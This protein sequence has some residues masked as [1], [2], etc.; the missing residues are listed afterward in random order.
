MKE[1]FRNGLTA[2]PPFLACF[3]VINTRYRYVSTGIVL[4]VLLKLI[5]KKFEDSIYCGVWRD[6]SMIS[7]VSPR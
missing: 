5:Y 1:M 7:Q 2:S 6:T 3:F 4:V